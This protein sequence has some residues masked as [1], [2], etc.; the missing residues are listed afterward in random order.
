MALLRHFTQEVEYR[1][2]CQ[3]FCLATLATKLHPRSRA[4]E[5]QQ[6][7][8]LMKKKTFERL[9]V[10]MGAVLLGAFLGLLLW[11][12]Y[13]VFISHD[14]AIYKENGLIENAQAIMLALA[15]LVFIVPIALEKRPDKLIYLFC[16]FTCYGLV[17]RELDV[18]KFSLVPDSLKTIWHGIGR[19]I[20][21]T[22]GIILILYYASR[23]LPYYKIAFVKFIKSTSG[24]LLCL[25]IIFVLFGEF[26]EKQAT[27]L[28]HIYFEEIFELCGYFFI[29]TAAY[30]VA[31]NSF[32]NIMTKRAH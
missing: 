7:V 26:L 8:S 21:I 11:T 25:A 13:S 4:L 27:V 17:L 5:L 2:Y 28:H 18:E 31:V 14:V 23:N 9:F 15:C 16:S 29:L 12:G 20:T 1:P 19:N 24:R 6:L 22:A 30:A 10:V 32:F 3:T